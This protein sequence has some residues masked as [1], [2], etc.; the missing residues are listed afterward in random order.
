GCSLRL[1]EPG[2]FV[3]DEDK[4]FVFQDWPTEK[5]AEIVVS[6][7][8]A[9]LTRLI[10]EPV[11]RIQDI[12]AKVLEKRAVKVIRARTCRQDHLPA[13]LAPELWRERRSF[14][15]KFLQ[16]VYRNQT[17]CTTESAESLRATCACG[18]HN[19]A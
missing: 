11:I 18:P 6:L 8:C 13:W 16:C 14:D 15:S 12:I 5:A 1:A 7:R 10:R 19:S 4:S 3:G 9:R 17:A 2:T